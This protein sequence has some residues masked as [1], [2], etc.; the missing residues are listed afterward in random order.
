MDLIKDLES[1][2]LVEHHSAELSV[3]FSKKRTVYLGVDPTADSMH[4]GHLVPLLIMKR[5]SDAGHSIILLAGG[6][7][8]MIGDPKEKGERQLLDLRIIEK[9][10]KAI[11]AQ[12]Q[13]II[14]TRVKLVDNADWLLKVK[15]VDFLRD[16]GKHFTVN[17]LVK[18]D[19][20]RRR[21]E[22]PDE[23]ISYT[24]FAYSLLQG[25][26]FLVLNQK[27]GCDMQVGASDQWTNILSGVELIRRKLGKEAF[28]FTCPLV[29]DS[30]GK[31]FGKSEGNAVWLDPKKTSPFEFYQFWLN[32]PDEGIERYLK[33]YT[34][35]SVVE[36]DA[37]VELHRR[38][39]GK[40]EAQK[41]LAKLVTEIVH[42][43]DAAR[44]AA[45]VSDVLFG[46]RSFSELSKS[47][48]AMLA[49]EAPSIRISAQRLATGVTVIDAL[50]ES[51]LSSSKSDAR[52]LI[53]GKGVTINGTIVE[54]PDTKL[55]NTHF[56]G[57]L[58]L[59]R[60]GKQVVVL[61]IEK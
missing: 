10:K 1:R 52:R 14:G 33:F 57:N 60:R 44:S 23:S 13:N 48:L 39:P 61:T 46:N 31:K 19:I 34:F 26:D 30:T 28:A 54:S 22:T 51:S 56:V 18:R 53:E 15:L 5:L 36:I 43:K 4:V 47:E 7:T 11:R 41:M 35:M 38:N 32:L 27:Y 37:L 6:G 50:V 21:L 24:E 45:G 3:M 58:A 49:T 25:Y 55:T 42:G 29:T 2:G 17:E 8:G 40:R 20:I 16:I 9:N 59:L 12:F